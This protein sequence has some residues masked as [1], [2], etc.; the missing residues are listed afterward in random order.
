MRVYKGTEDTTLSAKP[1]VATIGNFDG[2]HRGH[3]ELICQ[4]VRRAK[5]LRM[6]S[7]V[8]TFRP[9]P[10][11]VLRGGSESFL[12]NTYEEKIALLKGLGVDSIVEVVFNRDFSETDPRDFVW[13][14]LQH[15]LK[16]Q[17]LYLGYDFAF[18]RARAGTVEVMQELAKE[19]GIETHVVQAQILEGQTISSSLIRKGLDSG[20]I[21]LVNQALGRA[22][23]LTGIVIK[24]EGRGRLLNIPTVNLRLADRKIPRLGVYATKVL[25]RGKSFLS[26]TNIGVNPTFRNDSDEMPLK[27]ESHIL[28]FSGDLY[29]AEL[30]IEFYHFL[31]GEE[32]FPSVDALKNQIAQ[33]I[34]IA[35]RYFEKLERS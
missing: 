17:V 16:V 11:T 19:I 2:V 27:I 7:M 33:D 23:S 29:G 28:D 15:A 25:W 18:G 32:K 31:R 24:G 20:D 14:I 26:V 21:S 34:T 4:V 6:E 35:R 8:I 13:N 3:Q 5:E 12:I 30:G 9:H 22:Y 10:T 1:V